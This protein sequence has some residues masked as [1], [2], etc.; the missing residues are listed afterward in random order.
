MEWLTVKFCIYMVVYNNMLA[1]AICVYSFSLACLRFKRVLLSVVV[2]IRA[3]RFLGVKLSLVYFIR[4]K[5]CK[6]MLSMNR[7]R[8]I[9]KLWELLGLYESK[10]EQIIGF[11]KQKKKETYM[12]V[13]VS[14]NILLQQ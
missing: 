8:Q 13:C 2:E 6:K 9:D 3:K 10:S 11:I 14:K 7:K 1:D 12:C 4:R 5:I